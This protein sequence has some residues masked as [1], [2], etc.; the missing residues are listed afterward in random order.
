[1]LLCYVI[2]YE[3]TAQNNTTYSCTLFML[4]LILGKILYTCMYVYVVCLSVSVRY[5]YVLL[6]VLLLYSDM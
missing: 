5:F 2:K 6:I 3:F 1:M 4:C